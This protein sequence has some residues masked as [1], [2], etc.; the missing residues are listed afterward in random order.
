V[1]VSY[2]QINRLRSQKADEAKAKGY[3]LASYCSS[4]TSRLTD[5]PIGENAF[6]LEDNTLQPFCRI[7]RCVVTIW[8]GNHIGH[9]AVIGDGCFIA[10]PRRGLGRGAGRG[11]LL[12]RRQRD[13]AGPYHDRRQLR[14]RSGRPCPVRSGAR[15]GPERHGHPRLARAQPPAPRDMSGLSE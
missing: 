12:P 6:I 4:R 10:V 2:T 1:A 9:H 15:L 3:A 5:S 7:G 11:Q 14:G 13:L 8:S